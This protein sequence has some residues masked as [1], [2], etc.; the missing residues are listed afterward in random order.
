MKKIIIAN[1]HGGMPVKKQVCDFLLEN[2]YQLTDLG[3]SEETSVDYTDYAKK[4]CKEFLKGNYDFGILIC[5]TGIGMSMAANKIRNIRCALLMDVFS[6]K[7]AKEHNHANFVALGGRVRY[8]T[9]VTEILFAYIKAIPD[10]DARHLR[11]LE[12]IHLLE[13]FDK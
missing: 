6:A 3:V 9:S 1:D 2:H 4:A 8:S 5:G 7:M 10:T 13:K 11:R 12:K